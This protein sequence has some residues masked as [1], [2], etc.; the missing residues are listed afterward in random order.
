MK[1][2][3]LDCSAGAAGDMLLGAL[4]DAG[5]SESY[6]ASQVE[7]LRLEGASLSFEETKRSGIRSLQAVVQVQDVGA[8]R[9][10]ELNGI[11]DG[12]GLDPNVLERARDVFALLTGAESAVHGT[13]LSNAHLHEAGNDDAL[14]DIVGTCAALADLGPRVIVCSPLPVGSG[15]VE[16]AHGNLPVPAPATVELLRGVPVHGGG[17][18]EVITPTGAALVK[19][20]ADRFDDLPAMTID[21]AGYGAGTQER[22]WPNM[23]RAFVG[24]AVADDS[25]SREAL[26]ME[27]NLDDMSPELFPYVIEE[28][29]RA[30]AQDAWTAPIAMKKGRAAV[31]LSVLCDEADVGGALDV[32]YRETTTLGVR[33]RPVTKHVL[34]REW[35]TVEIEGMP[36][37]VKIGRR[38]GAVVN[39]KPEYEDAATVARDTGLPLKEV[40]RR[41]L[42]LYEPLE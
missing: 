12:A 34:E 9:L 37:R 32:L 42:D 13:T 20:I 8:R 31:T 17:E 1:I 39:A 19:T 5:A 15:R 38:D 35:V 4:V 21:R 23:V 28:L 11:L 24:E 30:G 14:I 27:T 25:G 41:A 7:K 16:A 33:T 29:L 10:P 18:G 22:E 26:L 3:Y 2:L 36:V 40:Y 6:V